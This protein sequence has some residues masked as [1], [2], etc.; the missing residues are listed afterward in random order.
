[1]RS[2]STMA[3]RRRPCRMA[4]SG[5]A[6]TFT[7]TALVYLTSLLKSQFRATLSTLPSWVP[8]TLITRASLTFTM[9][10]ITMRNRNSARCTSNGCLPSPPP[11]PPLRPPFRPLPTLA[12]TAV[13]AVMTSLQVA[14][15]T[16][17]LAM[18][19]GG[20]VTVRMATTAQ[21]DASL[22]SRGTLASR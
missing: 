21:V 19:T 7:L 22:P 11:H 20:N 4:L 13:M 15:A 8:S 14:F 5:L 10:M 12:T 1:V 3:V 6:T 17:L 9:A 2:S 16:K 18:E